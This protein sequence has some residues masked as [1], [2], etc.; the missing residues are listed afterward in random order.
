[1]DIAAN[2]S[3]I[4][5]RIVAAAARS[6]RTPES[7]KLLAVTKTVSPLSIGKAIEAGISM[8]GENYVQEAKEKI[9]AIEKSIQWHMIGHLQ[10]N[11][12]KYA[13]KLFDYIHSVDRIDLA[14]ELDKKARLTGRKIN[15]LIEVNVSG[16]KTKDGIPANDAINLIKNVSQSE[17]LSVRGL[18][19]MAPFLANPEDAR[20]YFSALR[21]LRDNITREGITGIHMEELSMGMTDDFEVAIEEGATIVRIGRAIFGKRG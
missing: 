11:K 7:I 21:N 1:M 3:T 15:I 19:T 14:R 17:N 18:M 8:F 4:R 9:A 20:P 6:Q 13:V 10:T 2:I 5:Q 12:A 16:E